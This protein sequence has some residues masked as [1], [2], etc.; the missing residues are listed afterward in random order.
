MDQFQLTEPDR[1]GVSEWALKEF[2]FRHD[3]ERD[4]HFSLGSSLS[5]GRLCFCGVTREYKEPD[6]A[7]S[8]VCG[9]ISPLTPSPRVEATGSC[10]FP[11]GQVLLAFTSRACKL[12]HV[13]ITRWLITY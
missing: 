5:Q 12:E 3:P 1:G 7:S 8:Y 4:G 11:Y 13:K 9:Q 6:G 10:S 2:E